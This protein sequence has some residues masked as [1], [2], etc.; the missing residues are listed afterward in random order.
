MQ[1]I[2]HPTPSTQ[3]GIGYCVGG[4]AALL[5]GLVAFGLLCGPLAIYLGRE[6]SKRGATTFGTV[7]KVGGWAETL[8]TALSVL[9]LLGAPPGL[10]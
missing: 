1:D 2:T 5:V 9:A 10:R 3:N 4:L 6:G 7:V 8:V